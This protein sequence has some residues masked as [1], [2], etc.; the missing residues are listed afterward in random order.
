[1]KTEP[2]TVV[3]RD[4]S[5]AETP[6]NVVICEECDYA[7]FYLFI[8][9]GGHQHIQCAACDTTFCDGSCAKAPTIIIP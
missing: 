7:A 6:A 3:A 9:E 4:G 1:M 2:T 8:L 5:G